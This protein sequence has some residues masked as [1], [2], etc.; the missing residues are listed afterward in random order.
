MFGFEK[1]VWRKIFDKVAQKQALHDGN[2]D[3]TYI[4]FPNC[5]IFMYYPVCEMC[6]MYKK[7][8]GEITKEKCSYA[9]HIVSRTTK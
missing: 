8:Q 6:I 4:Y 3:I 5:V 7:I 1:E 2:I 9:L